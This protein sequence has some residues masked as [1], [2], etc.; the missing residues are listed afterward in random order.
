RRLD[1]YRDGG[2]VVALAPVLLDPVVV[3]VDQV[4]RL[5]GV[6]QQEIVALDALRELHG[7]ALGVRLAGRQH[8]HVEEV[9]QRQRGAARRRVARKE[10]TVLPA[11]GAGVAVALV[12]HG[13]AHRDAV[14]GVGACRRGGEGRRHQVGLAVDDLDRRR[15]GVLQRVLVQAH[16]DVDLVKAGGPGEERLGEVAVED[17][18]KVPAPVDAGGGGGGGGVPVAP[19]RVGGVGGGVGGRG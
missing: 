5:V 4:A 12:L 8:P 3:G 15:A 11:V 13:P 17:D 6:E 14:A 1:V 10:G 9:P 18:V 7:P 16:E 19:A 2:D